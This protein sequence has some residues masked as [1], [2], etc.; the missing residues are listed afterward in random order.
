MKMYK[1]G[2][3]YKVEVGAKEKYF[4]LSRD[5]WNKALMKIYKKYPRLILN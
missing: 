2:V 4:R 5:Y 3:K 1:K